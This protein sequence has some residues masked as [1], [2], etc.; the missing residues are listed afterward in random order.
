MTL[1]P[2]GRRRPGFSLL[3][4]VVVLWA[5][6]IVA[7]LGTELIV[8]G[9]KTGGMSAAAD[10]RAVL[11]GELAQQFRAD[12]ARA[13]ATPDKLGDAAAGPDCLILQL[14]GGTT[15]VYRWQSESLTR[16]ERTGD[17]EVRRP[18]PLTPTGLRVEFLRPK[19]GLVTLRL[20][21]TPEMGPARVADVAAA[22]GGDLR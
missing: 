12:V 8:A 2:T 10:T 19:D 6:G 7:F 20:T 21:E 18:L 3:E 13:D 1:R 11:R 14:P 17:R 9:C 15:V 16:T 22:L 4:M 5:L